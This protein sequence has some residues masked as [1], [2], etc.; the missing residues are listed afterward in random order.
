MN[1]EFV[2]NS[3]PS[4]PLIMLNKNQPASLKKRKVRQSYDNSSMKQFTPSDAASE[5]LLVSNQSSSASNNHIYSMK[6]PPTERFHNES[7]SCLDLQH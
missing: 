6:S 3:E 4:R 7:Q 5:L 1:L 2:G